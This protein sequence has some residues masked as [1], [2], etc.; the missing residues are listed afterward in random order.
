MQ[1]SAYSRPSPVLHFFAAAALVAASHA[2]S[3][4]AHAQGRTTQTS[5]AQGVT[6]KVTPKPL[7]AGATDWEFSVVLDTH[8]GS[9]DDDLSR[10]AVLS[11]DGKD[12]APSSWDGAAAGGHHREGLLKFPAP[13]AQP[14]KVELRIR[15]SGESE[16][17][18]FRWE[19]HSLR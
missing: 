7:T 17:R 5:A 2:W 11:V 10:T 15:R 14:N 13:T 4:G 1:K 16:P 6:L 12:V 18:I 9:L 8:S 3:S 19:G